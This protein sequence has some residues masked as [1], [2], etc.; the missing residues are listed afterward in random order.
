MSTLID[1]LFLSI[2][3]S[4]FIRLLWP[5]L[6][7][8]LFPLVRKKTIGTVIKVDDVDGGCGNELYFKTTV[9]FRTGS[10]KILYAYDKPYADYGHIAS[11]SNRWTIGGKVAVY[12][13][14]FNPEFNRVAQ[15]TEEY[16]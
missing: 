11:S 3:L 9:E 7:C 10:G 15:T 5:C 1:F 6:R 12:Y 4:I 13:F 14:P 8:I 2:L 16:W